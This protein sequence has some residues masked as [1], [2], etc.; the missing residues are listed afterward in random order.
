MRHATLRRYHG[1]MLQRAHEDLLLLHLVPPH[2][3][4]MISEWHAAV[5]VQAASQL[6]SQRISTNL[7]VSLATIEQAG[8]DGDYG[9]GQNISRS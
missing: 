8:A 3:P 7:P 1:T 2:T 4:L 9:T 5:T 6:T